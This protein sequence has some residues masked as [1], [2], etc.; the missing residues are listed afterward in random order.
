[1]RKDNDFAYREQ[2]RDRALLH[3]HLTREG[4]LKSREARHHLKGGFNRRVLMLQTGRKTIETIT[5]SPRDRP[6]GVYLA[7]DLAIQLNAYYLNLCG[8]L[9]NLAWAMQYEWDVMPGVSERATSKGRNKIG[10]F[11]PPFLKALE[12]VK[13]TL[14]ASLR[15]HDAWNQSLRSLRDPAA[16]RVPLFAIPGWVD[17]QQA[18][19]ARRLQAGAGEKG[20]AG[21][22]HGMMELIHQASNLGQY[23][24]VMTAWT[25]DG[26]QVFDAWQ[27][28]ITD[29]KTITDHKTF[30]TVAAI[31]SA[32][33]FP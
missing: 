10:L 2:E 32:E 14:Q 16:H 27:T 3:E 13:P 9:D 5:H 7:T 33:L 21:D 22:H 15:Q 6:I 12:K 23:D 29:Y 26:E 20:K 17:E 18:E 30:Q 24:P 19:E 25:P 11:V 8:A 28:V 31:V 4:E 1:M